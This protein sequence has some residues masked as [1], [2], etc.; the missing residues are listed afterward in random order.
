MI[1]SSSAYK[2]QLDTTSLSPKAKIIVDGVEY[3]GDVIKEVP[4]IKHSSTKFIGT[5]PVKTVNF[6]IYDFENELDFENKEIEVYKGLVV[7]NSIEY[8]K[9]G[10]FI[11]RAENIKTNISERTISFRRR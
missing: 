7:N 10:I 11:P 3:L 8:L 1:S 5:F 6:S 4:K 9:Q 2:T